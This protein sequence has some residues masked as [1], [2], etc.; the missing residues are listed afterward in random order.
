M[1]YVF[2]FLIWGFIKDADIANTMDGIYI[3][4]DGHSHK[5]MIEP[6]LGK[7][8][9]IHMS[10]CYGENLGVLEFEYDGN[11]TN[12]NGVNINIKNVEMDEN[13]LKI[14]EKNRKIANDNLGVVLYSI[15]RGSII[16][17]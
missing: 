10:G 17:L 1:M 4:I 7:S 3:I 6:L 11:I 5:L 8:T 2:Y 12:I 13:I 16:S 14:I 9:V 15:D